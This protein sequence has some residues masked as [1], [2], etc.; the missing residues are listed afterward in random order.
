[1][2]KPV[3][4]LIDEKIIN[5]IYLIRGKKV[6]LDFELAELYLVET[7][8]LKRQVKR[9]PERFP[10]DFMFQLTTKEFENLRSQIGASSWGGTRYL[11]MVFTEQGVAML[12]SVLNSSTAIEVNIQ[13]IRIFTKMKEML[14]TNKDILLKLQKIETKLLAHDD[15]IKLIFDYLKKLLDPI[16]AAPRK[17][18]GFKPDE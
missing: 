11:P 14:L 9:N 18:I 2:A 17:R 13:I 1:M 10:G 6:M 8:Q 3:T 7:K 4:S 5:K 15:D 16:P 12:S